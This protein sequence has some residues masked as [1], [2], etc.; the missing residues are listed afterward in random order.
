MPTHEEIARGDQNGRRKAS[1][2]NAA[3]SGKRKRRTSDFEADWSA[4][5]G[6]LLQ[7]VIA[8]VTSDGGAIRFGYSRDGGT[9]AVGI[10]GDGKP[11]TEFCGDPKNVDEWLEGF[12]L[13]FE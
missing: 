4:V 5:N 10:Y 2:G 1:K 11:F 8:N 6:Q 3:N 7:Q 9:Y 13:D 12:R